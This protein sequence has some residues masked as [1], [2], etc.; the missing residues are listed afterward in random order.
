MRTFCLKVVVNSLNA[1]ILIT[2]GLTSLGQVWLEIITCAS[3]V[4]IRI[5]WNKPLLMNYFKEF[6][7]KL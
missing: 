2:I 6:T 3:L 5:S 4:L 7:R 1:S